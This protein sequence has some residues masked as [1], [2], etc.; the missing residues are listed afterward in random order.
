MS[1][2]CYM[3]VNDLQNS[4]QCTMLFSVLGKGSMCIVRTRHINSVGYVLIFKWGFLVWQKLTGVLGF[5][6]HFFLCSLQILVCSLWLEHNFLSCRR[7]TT[8]LGQFP[9]DP[10]GQGI[11]C[12]GNHFLEM[13]DVPVS[14]IWPL[15]FY[16]YTSLPGEPDVISLSFLLSCS[17]RCQKGFTR[18][19]TESKV[20]IFT[21]KLIAFLAL[22]V[23]ESME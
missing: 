20:Q 7:P 12:S 5:L 15:W 10:A 8:L 21:V 3:F 13:P 9:G 17:L 4:E 1:T 6:W 16:E 14:K 19:W 11:T 23:R 22:P 18:M 2:L